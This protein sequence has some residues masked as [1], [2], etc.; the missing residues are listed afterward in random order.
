MGLARE[1]FSLVA[2][3]VNDEVGD[4][5]AFTNGVPQ[6]SPLSPVALSLYTADL[7]DIYDEKVIHDDHSLSLYMFVD[8][9]F[10]LCTSNSLEKNVTFLTREFKKIMDWM[11]SHGL[12]VDVEKSDL[13]HFSKRRNHN[14]SPPI[15]ITD[16]NNKT[17]TI[18]AQKSMRWLGIYFDRKLTFK[19]HVR[20]MTARASSS[21]VLG[22][23]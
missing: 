12:G 14:A 22:P 2:I 11:K 19:E 9:G 23:A 7:L 5:E 13:M 4:Q 3:S 15:T 6:G 20:I 21:A 10:L 18:V 8:D 1:P 16:T 17:E